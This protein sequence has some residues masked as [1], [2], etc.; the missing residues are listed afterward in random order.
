MKK[1]L[2]YIEVIISI[3]LI[4]ICFIPLLSMLYVATYS[5][6]LS[7][8]IYITNLLSK[9]MIVELE[10]RLKNE[11]IVD[12]V[13]LNNNLWVLIDNENFEEEYKTDSYDYYV[14]IQTSK[15]DIYEYKTKSTLKGEI[16]NKI[17]STG[18]FFNITTDN[19]YDIIIIIDENTEELVFI[20]NFQPFMKICIIN[21]TLKNI[22]VESSTDN[23]ILIHCIGENIEIDSNIN[24]NII[25][26]KYI[27]EGDYY[28]IN[29]LAYSDDILRA[30]N[31]K[32]ISR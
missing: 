27:Y 3:T 11:P 22:K 1:G 29:V 25:Y 21:S 10:S 15:N 28:I 20:D 24:G 12:E 26:S 30:S 32:V 14:V 31:M 17:T 7:K 8:D 18:E 19:Y 5:D 16:E 23:E 2:S 4:S 6:K 13:L 9:N